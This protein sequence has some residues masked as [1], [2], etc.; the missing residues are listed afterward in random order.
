M[1]PQI[2]TPEEIRAAVKQSVDSGLALVNI[3]LVG[4]ERLS[5]LNLE[6]S[7]VALE[8]VAALVRS[9]LAASNL[10]AAAALL[11]SAVKPGVDKAVAQGRSVYEIVTQSGDDAFKLVEGKFVE[12]RKA[13]AQALE[14]AAK[15]APV[16]SDVALNAVKQ[17]VSAADAAYAN[18]NRVVKQAGVA[19]EANVAAATK[20]TLDAVSGA[21][22]KP[23]RI[24]A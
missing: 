12:T 6:A 1:N 3:A 21:G 16:G 14:Q 4:A 23:L 24:A 2:V 17:V 10:Q 20:A 19:A 13:L 15:S 18:L 5:A 9:V 8:D 7:R 11:Q 22:L